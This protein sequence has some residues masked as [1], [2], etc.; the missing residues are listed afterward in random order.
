[1]TSFVSGLVLA[2][3]ASR[4]FGR[5]KQLLLYRGSPLIAQVTRTALNSRALR[6]VLVVIGGASAEILEA[7]DFGSARVIRAADFASGCAAS[8]R[9][10]MAA[11]DA[12]ADALVVLLGDQPGI[13]TSAIDRAVLAW[14]ERHSPIV[15]TSYRGR[16]GHPMVFS[17]DLFD[18]LAG[19]SG[20][21]AAWKIVDARMKDVVRVELDEPYPVDVNT[22]DDYAQL[23]GALSCP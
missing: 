11:I 9:S 21:K 10:G 19:L 1:M 2:A 23:V 5:P 4:R 7:V 13:E 6:E 3:G 14:R 15:A 18:T 16:L 22:P 17:R 8:Y 12:R 20:D